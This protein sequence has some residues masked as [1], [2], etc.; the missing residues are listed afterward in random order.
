MI[1]KKVILLMA[2]CVAVGTAF[3]AC[4]SDDDLVQQA[5]VVPEEN[6]NEGTPFSVMP[7]SGA[8][9]A[10][11][12]NSNAWDG[13]NDNFVECFKLYGKQADLTAWMKNVVFTRSAKDAAWV[14]ARDADGPVASLTWPKDDGET[15]LKESEIT[16]DFYAITD[17]AI[18]TT[19]NS[20]TGVNPWMSP[21]GSFT[22]ALQPTSVNISWEDTGNPG[23][24]DN[25]DIQIVDPAELRDLMYA[26]TSKMESETTDGKLPLQFHHAL[27][28]LTIQAKFLS[29]GEYDSDPTENGWAKVK[30]VAFCGLNTVGTFAMT[31]STGLGAWSDLGTQCMYYYA[32]PDVGGKKFDVQAQTNENKANPAIQTL[33]PAGEWLAI[34]QTATACS[35]AYTNA[36]PTTGAYIVLIVEDFQD[37]GT[38]FPLFYPIS[39][40]LNAGKNRVITIDIAEG[41]DPYYHTKNP[42]ECDLFY[43]PSQ[44]GGSGS[45]EFAMDEEEF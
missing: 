27:S 42:A 3:V 41:R 35:I 21:E 44:A 25:Q 34:P 5:P 24:L 7:Y 9:R 11:L 40:T 30:A 4:S 23:S 37:E 16:T 8:T 15:P 10:T 1:M 45:R 31:P 39:T 32:I 18:S 17:N 33:V 19:D 6:V 2:A 22:Y 14:A 38:D 12:F 29:D 26:T 13:T 20:L 28:G 36:L 43:S